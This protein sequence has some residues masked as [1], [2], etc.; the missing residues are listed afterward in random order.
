MN[1]FGRA[2]SYAF[3]PGVNLDKPVAAMQFLDKNELQQYFL[4][5]ADNLFSKGSYQVETQSHFYQF[6]EL[7]NVIRLTNIQAQKIKCGS[8]VSE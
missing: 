8:A 4:I 1:K 7:G 6:N 5:H 3:L 2:I